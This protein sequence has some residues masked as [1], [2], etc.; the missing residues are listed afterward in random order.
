MRSEKY[1]M[2]SKFIICNIFIK[3]ITHISGLAVFMVLFLTTGIFSFS[4]AQSSK[5]VGT[6][7]CAPY[8]AAENTPPSPYLANNTLRQIVRVSIGGDTLRVK[9]SNCTSSTPLTMNSVNIAVSTEVGGSAIDTSTIKQLTFNG[10]SSVTINAY[11][12]V[13]SDSFVFPLTPGLQLA[14]TIYYGQ[15]NTAPDMTFHY[16]S[17]TD[18]YILEGN[19]ATSE[20]F[21]DATIVE[22]WYTINTIDVLAPDSSATVVVL[23]NSITD[24][25]GLHGGLK[26]KWTDIFSER[27]LQN[28]ATSHVAVLNLGIGATWLTSSGVSRFQQDVLD[29]SGVRW[30]II[31]YGVNDIGGN[32][33]ADDIINAYKGLIAQAH[34]QNVR[35]YGA[36]ITPFQGHSY[37]SESREAV[38]V[39]VNEWI[40]AQGNFDSLIDF[41]KA[42]R[43]P[44]DTTRLLQAYSND[45]LH[46][47][48]AGYAL[49][50]QSVDLSLFLA[51][52]T[53]FP[54][55]VIEEHYFEPECAEIGESWDI[56]ESEQ[57]SNGKYVTV[58][59]GIQSLE[60]P[61]TGNESLIV[62]PF[63]V[64]TTDSF[65]IYGRI[66]CPTYDD[67]SFW[68]KVDDSSF[69]LNNG[70]V[71]S[72]WEWKSFG[73]YMLAKGEHTL[74]IAYR[75]DGALLDNIGI[76]NSSFSPSDTGKEAENLCNPTDI[77]SEEKLRKTF[78]L[79]QNYP[80]PFNPATAI[81]FKLP[82]KNI[83]TLK[84]FDITGKEIFTLLNEETQAGN[85]TISFN[86]AGLAS[87]VYLYQL[88]A[89]RY[90]E[91]KKMLLLK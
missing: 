9:F 53:V 39:E 3:R 64:D 55:A 90:N 14:I 69:E 63:S 48:V 58:K 15:I 56:V 78:R 37:Y 11:S 72:G 61:P 59:A 23:G 34:A 17:R 50:G 75:E 65:T 25:Y 36:T 54:Q 33:P 77:K 12:E 86:G 41:D 83:V 73:D 19:H 71:T 81:S 43:N 35:V 84:V 29:Q 1:I 44:A 18:S 26:N 13:T 28:P 88:Q 32:A 46:P 91:I 51:G 21:D 16:G 24:G 87:G 79:Q 67:D 6:W 62:I 2:S 80:N 7:S 10:D 27:L 45:W 38:R 74:T 30:A 31:F 40:R 49:L 60:G 70:L 85:Y 76:S 66:N 47:N 52:D 42:I 82:E 89:G 5:W 8:A 20:S 22:R 68:V 57:A 4:T